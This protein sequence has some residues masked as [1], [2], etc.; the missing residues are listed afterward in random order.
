MQNKPSYLNGF[1]PGNW[2]QRQK[3]VAYSILGC[4]DPQRRGQGAHRAHKPFPV[5]SK[6]NER[7][8]TE[9]LWRHSVLAQC[10]LASHAGIQHMLFRGITCQYGWFKNESKLFLNSEAMQ[11]DIRRE[12]LCLCQSL[13]QESLVP[14]RFT[15]LRFHL[16]WPLGRFP[17]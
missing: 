13:N 8:V 2:L 3:Q 14:L 15:H 1:P 4:Q 16:P 12:V 9:A 10:H 5:G 6:V 7:Q 17:H 11:P